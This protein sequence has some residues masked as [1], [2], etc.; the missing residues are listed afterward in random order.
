MKVRIF[1]ELIDKLGTMIDHLIH[2]TVHREAPVLI[3][4]ATLFLSLASVM[5]RSKLLILLQRHTAAL[6]KFCFHTN[7]FYW[8]IN[9]CH[10][11]IVILF[12]ITHIFLKRHS[13]PFGIIEIYIYSII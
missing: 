3:T 10:L 13:M 4:I 7:L 5:V 11:R 8:Y 6:A 12:R 1:I 2:R 9:L